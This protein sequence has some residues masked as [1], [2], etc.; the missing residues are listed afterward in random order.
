MKRIL[1]LLFLSLAVM[2]G[3]SLTAFAQDDPTIVFGSG[4]PNS[5]YGV[6]TGT[7]G[8]TSTSFVCDDVLNTISSGDTW[9]ATVY[10]LA[11]VATYGKGMFAIPTTGGAASGNSLYHATGDGLGLPNNST[12][13]QEAYNMTAY[14]GNLLLTGTYSAAGT[15]EALSWAIW[16]IMDTPTAHGYGDPGGGS[17]S[18][19]YTDTGLP[20]GSYA[21]CGEAWVEYAGANELSYSNAS[22]IFYTPNSAISAGNEK[23]DWAQEFIGETPEPI[24]MALMGTFLTLAALG[25]GKKKLFA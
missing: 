16:D 7:I 8:G 4:G 24:S 1:S 19:G 10:T 22:I 2:L 6:Y 5:P 17:C 18:T 13:I 3:L 20:T 12:G 23:G 14:L 11:N 15:I 25:L 9:S 21:G